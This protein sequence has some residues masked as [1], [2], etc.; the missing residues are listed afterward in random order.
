MKET[1]DLNKMTSNAGMFGTY[2][3]NTFIIAKINVDKS[4]YCTPFESMR[5]VAIFK[6]I[7]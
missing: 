4:M 3:I 2:L 6:T 5:E 7:I 1:I